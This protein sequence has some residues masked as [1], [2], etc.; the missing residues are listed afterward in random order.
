MAS[1]IRVG[2][3]EGWRP[4]A[5]LVDLEGTVRFGGPAVPGAADAL[6]R[7]RAAGYLLRF[8]TN[9]DSMSAE[10]ICA[11]LQEVGAHASPSEIFSPVAALRQ[12]VAAHPSSTWYF[13]LSS[14]L[15][16][17]FERLTAAAA[18]DEGGPP[19]SKGGGP[20]DYVVIGDFRDRLTYERLN[21]AYRHLVEGSKLVALQ[22]QKYFMGPDGRYL[23]NG[24][25]VHMLEWAAEVE[26]LVLG[27]PSAQFYQLALAELGVSV[28][29]ALVV[30]DDIDMDIAGAAAVGARSVLVRTGKFSEGALRASP[31][32]PDA[33]L[34]SLA[35]LPEVLGL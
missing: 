3:P 20:P 34:D 17:E 14:E 16:P 23:D 2:L 22:R 25:F 7:L 26:A 30:G 5:L 32:K 13:L 21:Q 9:I 10:S 31:C 8:V 33:V 27:K 28:D 18:A 6:N 29:E 19:V 24:A 4:K 11:G 15:A 35:A 1:A 12:F